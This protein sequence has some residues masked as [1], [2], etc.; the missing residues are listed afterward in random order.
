MSSTGTKATGF[1]TAD[2]GPFKCQNC[3]KWNSG[4]CMDDEVAADH[5]IPGRGQRLTADGR[6]RTD[7]DECCNEF[8]SLKDKS[9]PQPKPGTVGQ[10]LMA[11]VM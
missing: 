8:L 9:R 3:Q 1:A 6:I 5:G 2:L 10:R 11:I 4:V 7:T